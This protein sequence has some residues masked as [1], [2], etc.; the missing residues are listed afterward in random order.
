MLIESLTLSI[1][2]DPISSLAWHLRLILVG[3]G[4]YD[5]A[6]NGVSD[7][8]MVMISNKAQTGHFYVLQSFHVK[9]ANWK[10]I[11]P[12]IF[13]PSIFSLWLLIYFTGAKIDC[14]ES[15]EF[16]YI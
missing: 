14:C 11:C 12:L 8:D 3:N 9:S 13:Q 5:D 16:K 2:T 15:H 1:E 10:K 6:L 7:Q 4:S